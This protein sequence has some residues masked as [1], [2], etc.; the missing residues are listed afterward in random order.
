[1]WFEWESW[2]SF[3]GGRINSTRWKHHID[4]DLAYGKNLTAIKQERYELYWTNP[5]GKIPQ[6]NSRKAT[7][8]S[9]RKPSKLNEQ[10]MRETAEGAFHLF[11]L[12]Y[13]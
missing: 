2:W 3:D 9:S 7:F 8:H 6:S 11:N 4:A 12:V 13:N 1:M 5:G 10:D